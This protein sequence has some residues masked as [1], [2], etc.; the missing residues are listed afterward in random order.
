MRRPEI[1]GGFS[2]VCPET[3]RRSNDS[4]VGAPSPSP[5]PA[6]CWPRRRRFYEEPRTTLGVPFRRPALRASHSP[7]R[8]VRRGRVPERKVLHTSP[9]S[10]ACGVP[11]FHDGERLR[12]GQQPAG[13]GWPWH[14]GFERVTSGRHGR[15]SCDRPA[16]TKGHEAVPRLRALRA[17]LVSSCLTL[18]QS[19]TRWPPR[20]P[21]SQRRGHPP[22]Q[23]GR[24]CKCS[25][26]SRRRSGAPSG[27]P[28]PAPS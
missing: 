7:D 2:R 23:P 4:G 19:V 3:A 26:A 8:G 13:P 5:G 28:S 21:S 15:D 25:P 6:G 9:R 1:F 17:I 24:R 10:E 11:R 20:T 18:P 16:K 22:L 14:D 12:R 27:R